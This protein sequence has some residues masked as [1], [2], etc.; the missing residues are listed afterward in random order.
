[1][2]AVLQGLTNYG[3]IGIILLFFLLLFLKLLCGQM[4]RLM[5]RFSSCRGF[6]LLLRTGLLSIVVESFPS[7]PTTGPWLSFQLM[8]SWLLT[9][10]S[11]FWEVLNFSTQELRMPSFASWL[12]ILLSLNG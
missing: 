4:V 2:S 12:L 5:L 3:P 9:L 7:T 11:N 1:M 10:C 6:R 8:R